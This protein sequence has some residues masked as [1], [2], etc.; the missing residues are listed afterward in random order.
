MHQKAIMLLNAAET[1]MEVWDMMMQVN[2]GK[3]WMEHDFHKI[4]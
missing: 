2:M 1:I 4:H 3:S